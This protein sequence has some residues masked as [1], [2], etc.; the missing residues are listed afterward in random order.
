MKVWIRWA[1]V[2]GV[3]ALS[4]VALSPAKSLAASGCQGAPGASA[5]E[6]YCEAVPDADG[7]RVNP[8][9]SG[10]TASGGV[11]ASAS[12]QQALTKL[13]ADGIRLAHLVGRSHPTSSGGSVAPAGSGNS[14][15]PGTSSANTVGV[16]GP[17]DPSGSPLAAATKAV[18]RGPTAGGGLAWGLVGMS[19]LG[20][21]GAIVLRRTRGFDNTDGE[22]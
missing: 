11:G 21:G 15:K 18:G 14:A 22:S 12:T 6:Q 20:A 7:R 13:G 3:T 19:V 5:L 2:A 9:T 16:S 10:P 4:L 1:H 17:N 8:G